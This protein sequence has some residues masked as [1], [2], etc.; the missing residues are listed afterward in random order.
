[1]GR[2]G[3]GR[4][5]LGAS[6]GRDL[7]A[8][9]ASGRRRRER[10]LRDRDRGARP[11]SRL[12]FA[13]DA[14]SAARHRPRAESRARLAKLVA[15]ARAVLDEDSS[16]EWD[17]PRGQSSE[18]AARCAGKLAF[19][20]PGQGSQYVAMARDLACVFP[21]MPRAR[22]R[23][24]R[25]SSRSRSRPRST[26]VPRLRRATRSR[27]A[28]RRSRATRRGAAGARRGRASEAPRPRALRRPRRGGRRPQL[29]RAR[30]ARAAGAD[31][32][33]RALHAL[34]RARGRAHG[35]PAPGDRG[36]MLAV[37]APLAAIERCVRDEKLDLVLANRNAPSQG[38]LVG[39]ASRDRARR[40]AACEARGLEAR[41][42]PVAAAFHSPL[43]AAAA[44]PFRARARAA[45]RSRAGTIPVYANATPRRV[46]RPTPA[47]ARDL[48]GCQLARPVDFRG[49]G[50]AHATRTACGPSSRSD[51]RRA[52]GPGQGD[53]RAARTHHA[54]ALDALVG[55]ALGD[56]RPRAGPRP[57]R[58][59]RVSDRARAVGA[60]GQRRAPAADQA[61]PHGASHRRQLPLAHLQGCPSS[62]CR[63]PRDA[64]V[65]A[66]RA[67]R[68][69][70]TRRRPGAGARSEERD[71]G[72]RERDSHLSPRCVVRGSEERRRGSP[73]RPGDS[74]D[75][76]RHPGRRARAQRPPVRDPFEE[77]RERDSRRNSEHVPSPRAE[78]R[79]PAR[80][81]P[82]QSGQPARIPGIA[83]ADRLAPP[84]IPRG[85]GDGA[86]DVRDARPGSAAA[87][88]A[89]A[90]SRSHERGA[91]ASR[92]AADPRA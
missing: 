22:R 76:A 31:R 2:L 41:E 92:A 82:R 14:R 58:R 1:M 44:E 77:R 13:R 73:E 38:V 24:W 16:R 63:V 52:H 5:S 86:R 17:P 50:R 90:G 70:R 8:A 89:R 56:R 55:H 39:S 72:S 43:V 3:R 23:Q 48:L 34:A 36:P 21:E 30:R 68:D 67:S 61:A 26:R 37:H 88:R 15:T 80:S 33:R 18:G 10:H 7:G 74:E 79:P 62:A 59:P 40:R 32:R 84:S 51:R 85:P 19:L 71:R 87:R 83:G 49:D 65:R 12:A 29:R 57:A 4:R 69:A 20:F 81:L 11:R 91:R 60:C 64:S 53:A 66:R 78:R 42:L 25:R 45:S 35:R 75:Q 46:S 27:A 9:L 28:S 54:V 6:G 47:P